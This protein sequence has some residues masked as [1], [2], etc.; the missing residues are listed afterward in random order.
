MNL[1]NFYQSKHHTMTLISRADSRNRISTQLSGIKGFADRYNISRA[2]ALGFRAEG[3]DHVAK[4][5]YSDWNNSEFEKFMKSAQLVSVE[6]GLALASLAMDGKGGAY[7]K[8]WWVTIIQ[9]FWVSLITYNNRLASIVKANIN[10]TAVMIPFLATIMDDSTF[11]YGMYETHS[12]W[13]FQETIGD[14]STSFSA[15]WVDGGAWYGVFKS[16]WQRST[17]RISKATA[18]IAPLLRV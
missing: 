10:R 13:I 17:S 6:D 1:S 5:S 4:E 8:S 14:I 7:A 9:M 2:I 12:G 18:S 11:G 15:S 3:S 16:Y